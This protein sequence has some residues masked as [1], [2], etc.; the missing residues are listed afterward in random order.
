M[1]IFNMFLNF[2]IHHSTVCPQGRYFLLNLY[3]LQYGGHFKYN[4]TLK[5]SI[6]NYGERRALYNFNLTHYNRTTIFKIITN[7]KDKHFLI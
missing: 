6:L 4:L 7:T 3:I 1:L 2:K 5:S